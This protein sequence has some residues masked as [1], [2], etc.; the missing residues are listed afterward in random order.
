MA[1]HSEEF[2]VD[3]ASVYPPDVIELIGLTPAQRLLRSAEMWD[4]YIAYGG[5]FDPDLDP[6]S[7]F[8]DRQ[9]QSS[10]PPH[11]RTGLRLIRRC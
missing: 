2:L 5:S 10:S 8:F 7:P 11:G 1:K 3:P 4:I 6:Q 9:A